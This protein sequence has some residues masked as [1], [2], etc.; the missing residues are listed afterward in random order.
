MR[1][2]CCHKKDMEKAHFFKFP[3]IFCHSVYSYGSFI[4]Q[5]K[6]RRLTSF[7]SFLFCGL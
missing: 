6:R 1:N 2:C 5:L 3:H 7:Y 4:Q